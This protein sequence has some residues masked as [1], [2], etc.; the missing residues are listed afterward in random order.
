MEQYWTEQNRTDYIGSEK[1]TLCPLVLCWYTMIEVYDDHYVADDVQHYFEILSFHWNYYRSYSSALVR[2]SSAQLS[3]AQ[4]SLIISWTEVSIE[5]NAL[6]STTLLSSS[7]SCCINTYIAS[8]LLIFEFIVGSVETA[9]V[10]RQRR[11]PYN[12]NNISRFI[13]T[14][15]VPNIGCKTSWNVRIRC[16]HIDY[17]MPRG[18]CGC[19][20]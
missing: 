19:T 10:R 13:M 14:P 3:S 8:L 5:C 9:W 17:I 18:I 15:F 11:R 12:R 1:Y 20:I 7:L 6:N 2:Y 4:L 16:F